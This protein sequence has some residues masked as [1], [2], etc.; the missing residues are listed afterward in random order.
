[1]DSNACAGHSLL[2]VHL[3]EIS[4]DRARFPTR[5]AYPFSLRVVQE[6]ASVPLDAPVTFFAGENGSGKSTFL[7]AIAHRCGIHIWEN[8]GRTLARPNPFAERLYEFVDVRWQDGAMPGSFF[9]AEIFRNFAEL[10][11][12]WAA[13]DPGLLA[14]LGGAPLTE[15]SHGQCNMTFFEHRF[16]VPGLYLLDEPES[17]LSPRRQAELLRILSEA[18][19]RG[20]AQFIVATHS[21]ILLSLPGSRILSFDA[22]PVAEIAYRDTDSFRL[23]KQFFAGMKDEP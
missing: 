19:A 16:R 2:A 9:A 20:G 23:H 12:M 21:P 7:R 3:L 15:K 11:D 22:C 10:F 17:A 1:M 14:F 5:E 13:S 6:T 4:I 18:A 8:A